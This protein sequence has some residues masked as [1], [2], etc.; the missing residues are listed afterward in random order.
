MEIFQTGPRETMTESTWP[1]LVVS[2]G[3][4]RLLDCSCLR[5]HLHASP[6]IPAYLLP[7][8]PMLPPMY[9]WHAVQYLR[10][11]YWPDLL[12][13]YATATYLT[14]TSQPT[15]CLHVLTYA[16]TYTYTYLLPTYIQSTH[17]ANDHFFRVT[18]F[19]LVVYSLIFTLKAFLSFVS[20]A[21]S[22]ESPSTSLASWWHI[23]VGLRMLT[24]G[25]PY[26]TV[27]YY[28]RLI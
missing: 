9:T 6:H 2:A 20:L 11:Q 17:Q 26:H 19:S 22:S 25:M 18:T 27:P 16:C 12:S 7:L 28:H 4:D 1:C 3:G 10:A 21:W 24:H 5:A 14:H 13:C 15:S 23:C 8:P